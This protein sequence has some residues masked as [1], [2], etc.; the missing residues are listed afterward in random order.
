MKT[1]YFAPVF[2]S[3]LFVGTLCVRFDEKTAYASQQEVQVSFF[4]IILE[5]SV[6]PLLFTSGDVCPGFQ[7]Q[8]GFR[9]CVLS[10]LHASPGISSVADLGGALPA[11]APLRTKISLI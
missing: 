11:R 5:D 8:G 3:A 4:K 1:A 9:A 10:R 2:C 7:S 6:I